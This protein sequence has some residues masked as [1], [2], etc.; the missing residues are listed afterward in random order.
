[1]ISG[2][3]TSG[4]GDP[5]KLLTLGVQAIARQMLLQLAHGDIG[6][7]TDFLKP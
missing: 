7:V 1:V 6:Q 5:I 4:P 3:L 2:R